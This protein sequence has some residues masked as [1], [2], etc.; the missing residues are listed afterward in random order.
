M[1]AERSLDALSGDALRQR[2]TEPGH[3]V[4]HRAAD[5]GFGLLGRQC[6]GAQAAT[7][8]NFVAEH[9]GLP[10][11]APAVA[12]RLLP[13]QAPLVPDRLDVLVPLTGRGA[14]G[15]AR[16]GGCARRDDHR[17]GWV[18]LALSHGA[19]N[20]LAV[21]RTVRDH[22]GKGTGDLIEQ[23]ADLGGVALLVAR[24]LGREDL[25][26]AEINGQMKLTPGPLA[27]H[28]VLLRQPLARAVDLQPSCVDHDV[29]RSTR[30]GSRQRRSERLPGY[31]APLNATDSDKP[32]GQPDAWRMI[33]R[34]AMTASI[35]E[36]IGCHT[37][38][39]T[40]ITAYLANG[41]ALEYAQ[42]MAAHE[43]PRTT[44]LYDRT[45]ERLTQDEVERI[46]L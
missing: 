3:P 23:G 40:G 24:Q 25:A 7:D 19:V 15:R 35:V 21:I 31:A 26:G 11:R 30:L 20:G 13:A 6:P 43:S 39:A 28:T 17:H 10:K 16:H 18:G 42:E 36:A 2:H 8:D 44:K 4:E 38:R 22:R 5:P 37:F 41:G 29:N 9:G 45:K 12:D 34:R 1:G 33:R 27:A 32:M 14:R 46:R